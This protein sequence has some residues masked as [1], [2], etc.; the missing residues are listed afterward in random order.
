MDKIIV[1]IVLMCLCTK[2]GFAN[3]VDKTEE[4]SLSSMSDNTDKIHEALEDMPE[5]DGGQTLMMEWLSKNIIYPEQAIIDGIEGRVIV[6][7]VVEKDGSVSTPMILKGV[8]ETLDNE[9]KR[10]VLSMPK[11]KSG[12]LQGVPMRCYVTLPITFKLRTDTPVQSVEDKIETEYDQ[13]AE[14]EG[15]KYGIMR[16][17]SSNL[18]YPMEALDHG[19][20]GRVWVGF[21]VE[22]DGSLSNVSVEKDF[23]KWLDKEAVRAVSAMPK[24]SPAMKDN[25]PVRTYYRLPIDFSIREDGMVYQH[26][27]EYKYKK[28][29]IDSTAQMPMFPGGTKSLMN[30]MGKHIV[31]PDKALDKGIQ[32]RVVTRFTIEEDGMITNIEIAEKAHKLLDRAAL[33]LIEL[34]PAWIPARDA[35]GNPIRTIYTLPVKFSIR[36]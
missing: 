4:I 35:D 22:K 2:Y 10:V 30:W 17:L 28:A 24:W 26:K 23:N 5:F 6:R 8:C 1:V 18:E 15:G 7:F 33:D 27:Y 3:Q 16:Y 32:G 29:N 31:Y 34:M 21:V 9:A 13:I 36:E 12:T 20:Y 11:W 19:V 25:Q 14:F